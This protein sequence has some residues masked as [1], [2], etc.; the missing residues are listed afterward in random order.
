M[1][2]LLFAVTCC[3]G[4][5]TRASGPR[6][7]CGC[8]SSVFRIAALSQTTGCLI[9]NIFQIREQRLVYAVIADRAGVSSIVLLIDSS[10]MRQVV[11]SVGLDLLRPDDYFK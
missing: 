7:A 4:A 11:D 6:I 10:V 8:C 5:S 9:S 1:S 3:L 2:G